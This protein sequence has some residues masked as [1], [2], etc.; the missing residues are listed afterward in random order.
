MISGHRDTHFRFLAQLKNGDRI[1]LTTRQASQWF[2][3]RQMDV[4]D[5]RSRELLIEPGLDRLSLVTC[6][7]FDSLQ[8]G[9]PLR[10]VVTALPVSPRPPSSG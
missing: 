4:V 8:P 2:E 10:Y 7:P 5:S 3:V 6:Y 9:G 1:R